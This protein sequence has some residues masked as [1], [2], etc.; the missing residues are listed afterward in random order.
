MT[1][2]S[3]WRPLN[4]E[5]S[6]L[7]KSQNNATAIIDEK[8]ATEPLKAGAEHRTKQFNQETFMAEEDKSDMFDVA[9][10][11]QRLALNTA[12][13]ALID[14]ASAT[15]PDLRHRIVATVEAYITTLAPIRTGTRLC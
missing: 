12:I 7:I 11:A 9:T 10:G 8:F 1:D 5:N 3:K 15:D 4:I 6:R 2:L 13:Q 14:H